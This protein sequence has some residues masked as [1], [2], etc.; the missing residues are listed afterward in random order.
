[1][2]V[3]FVTD[4]RDA[5][6]ERFSASFEDA[7]GADYTRVEVSGTPAAPVFLAGSVSHAGWEAL[8]AALDAQPSVVVSGPL[9]TVSSKLVGGNYRHIG[10][11]WATDIMVSA[12]A[13][14]EALENLART[15]VGLHL[16]V[17]D[18][19]ATENALIAMGVSPQSI[20]RI[21]WGPQSHGAPALS[22]A[23]LGLPSGV[24]VVL[25]PRS[26]EA[27]YQPEVFLDALEILVASHP[28]LVAVL[29][30]SGSGLEQFK[31][32]VSEKGLSAHILWQPMRSAEEFNGLIALADAVVV[33][34]V[35]D[36]TSVTVMDAMAQGIPVVTSL[37]NGSSEWIM[38]G[39][40]GWTFPVG[41]ARALARALERVVASEAQ[42]RDM[43][44]SNARR[45]VGQKAGWERSR[46]MV[47]TEIQRLFTS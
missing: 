29:V 22:R 1:M 10:I 24:P 43:V 21:P 17:T 7:F 35:T 47:I 19:Y 14:G 45:L 5:H 15:V 44:T 16:V 34:T 31:E 40:T 26:I 38:D 2:R 28:T 39:V 33:T 27:H 20:C 37:T 13:S 18:N 9:D 30:E 41:D 32:L 8:R 4:R 3:F 42:L 11:S 46:G 25:Y 6:A 23:D 12:A 36:G